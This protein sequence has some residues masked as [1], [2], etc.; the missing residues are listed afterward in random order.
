MH[1]SR[2]AAVRSNTR[3]LVALLVL[4]ALPFG[5]LH[6]QQNQQDQPEASQGVTAGRL[7]ADQLTL[8][9][10]DS[11]AGRAEPRPDQLLRAQV[12]LDM[13]LSHAPEDV[14]LWRLRAELAQRMNDEA[15]YR[16]AL[17]Q[18]L[19]RNPHDDAAQYNLIRSLLARDQR[20]EDRLQRVENI[21]KSR[22]GRRLSLALRSRLGVY[23]ARASRELGRRDAFVAWLRQAVQLSPA[24][25]EAATQ[26]YQLAVQRGA[27]ASRVG[28][29]AINAVAAAPANPGARVRLARILISEGAYGAA[30][31]QYDTAATLA[32]G[33]L[34]VDA[35]A[36][37]ALARAAL[38]E[39][40]QALMLLRRLEPKP[41]AQDE[42]TDGQS[43]TA[44]AASRLPVELEL[45]RLAILDAAGR[46]L[47]AQRA[48]QRLRSQ[49]QQRLGD[50]ASQT[51]RTAG[52]T[53]A[54]AD[55][56]WA[57]LLFDR[58]VDAAANDLAALT[59]PQDSPVASL[60]PRL[61]AWLALRRRQTDTARPQLEKLLS[62]G[63]PF[64]GLGLAAMEPDQSAKIDYLRRTLRRSPDSLAGLLAAR[65]LRTAGRSADPSR[66]GQMLLNAMSQ[67]P[68]HLWTP[69]LSLSPWAE[70]E[71]TV[72]PA[73][74]GYLEPMR[75][76][77]TVRNASQ[78]PLPLS[79]G[80]GVPTRVLIA[81]DPSVDGQDVP[82]PE[83]IVVDVHRRL[84]LD[85]GESFTV[86]VRLDRTRLGAM[87][88]RRPGTTFS[89]DAS[90]ILGPTPTRS[91]GFNARPTGNVD[92]VRAIEVRG[93]PV[94]ESRLEQWLQAAQGGDA[95]AQ[96]RAM[97]RLMQSIDTL[98]SAL[99]ENADARAQRRRIAE[100]VAEQYG[101]FDALRR[102]WVVRFLPQ[103][104][105]ARRTFRRVLDP[106]K[107]SDDPTVRIV[108]LATH[109]G[110]V[111]DPV[112]AASLRHDNQ[113]IRG[114][115]EALRSGLQ[116]ETEAGA[117]M[118]QRSQPQ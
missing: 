18:Y 27:D 56:V 41:S 111:D 79:T 9:M 4:C 22:K 52:A 55:L 68:T 75:A 109:I 11:L 30:R 10:H 14:E 12:L 86:P 57:R 91:G 23:A 47:G 40:D 71:L 81:L 95:V 6:A 80:Q 76:R 106:A 49:L 20:L 3:H 48:Y 72:E 67:R 97:A 65:R 25:P 88:A 61:R 43:D 28:V 8:L 33:R 62:E 116:A 105:D 31:D 100:V 26:V 98:A 108:Y 42:Q 70:L 39:D 21:L 17:R 15:K 19:R 113:A 58:E 69:A 87:L 13:A 2:T 59:K 96:M 77:L 46:Q 7:L 103:S 53:Q 118:E 60:L 115:A 85:V 34:G 50:N 32:A 37:W 45:L 66:I 36:N 51:S 54:K 107:R 114:F 29:A 16:E 90:A 117:Q 93:Q 94:N 35:Y 84:E 102:A 5:E 101:Q 44:P 1:A 38:G 82:R 104:E 89:V 74:L 92:R 63:D 73:S 64:A 99:P 24:N 110:R 78:I 83:P 112:L